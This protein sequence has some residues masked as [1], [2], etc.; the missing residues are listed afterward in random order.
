MILITQPTIANK[1]TLTED[2]TG[3][4]LSGYG[5]QSKFILDL[6]CYRGKMSIIATASAFKFNHYKK[7]FHWISKDEQYSGIINA[8]VTD[9]G[10][11][12]SII[13]DSVDDVVPQLLLNGL[14]NAN[15]LNFFFT[16]KNGDVN[17]RLDTTQSH[18]LIGDFLKAC[19]HL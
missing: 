10:A 3:T 18:L 8:T 19:D 14:A 7:G 1:W 17:R 15:Q 6:I 2:A 5:E 9:S 4:V 11:A 13:F 12:L 16:T